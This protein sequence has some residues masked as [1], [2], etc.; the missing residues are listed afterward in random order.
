MYS[1]QINVG[2]FLELR[3]A[4]PFE[5][6]DLKPFQNLV[7]GLIVGFLCRVVAVS[8]LRGA[9]V[10]TQEVAAGIVA[11]MQRDNA[12]IERSGVVVAGS[13]VFTMQVER[14]CRNAGNP[15]QQTFHN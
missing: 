1:A 11:L 3:L 12:N 14:M 4:S 6:T 7:G 10:F 15:N 5:S 13:A 9:Q 8:D 2:R